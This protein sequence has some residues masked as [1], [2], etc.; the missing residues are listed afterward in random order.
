MRFPWRTDDKQ[1]EMVAESFFLREYT[2]GDTVIRQVR[3]KDLRV[4][5]RGSRVEG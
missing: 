2:K 5:G 1:R 3:V 4:E